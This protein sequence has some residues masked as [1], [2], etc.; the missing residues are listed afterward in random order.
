MISSHW[1]ALCC[2]RAG[3]APRR[4]SSLS[5]RPRRRSILHISSRW[6]IDLTPAATLVRETAAVDDGYLLVPIHNGWRMGRLTVFCLSSQRKPRRRDGYQP[7]QFQANVQGSRAT[8]AAM[9]LQGARQLLQR[10]AALALARAL[11]HRATLAFG[12]ANAVA[13]VVDLTRKRFG[14]KGFEAAV[15][16]VLVGQPE[17]RE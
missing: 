14:P 15:G 9:T 6:F 16:G 7:S 4:V 5:M 2:A 17:G 1:Q 10:D 8:T 11:L 13:V 3:V 12:A